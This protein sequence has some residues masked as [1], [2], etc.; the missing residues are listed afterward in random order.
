MLL[1]P[2]DWQGYSAATLASVWSN[3]HCLGPLASL[4]SNVQISALTT[5]LSVSHP[6]NCSLFAGIQLLLTVHHTH[7]QV[8]SFVLTLPSPCNKKQVYNSKVN[9]SRPD[10]FLMV[11]WS[12]KPPHRATVTKFTNQITLHKQGLQ[13]VLSHKHSFSPISVSSHHRM[14]FWSPV[15]GRT[16]SEW[17]TQLLVVSEC[18]FRD[19]P[20]TQ[21]HN[22]RPQKPDTCLVWTCIWISVYLNV[23]FDTSKYRLNV[24]FQKTPSS[25]A[26]T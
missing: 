17:M 6:A 22:I 1:P 16:C 15:C 2:L 5:E 9:R 18:W 7:M 11:V 3:Q 13:S 24:V 26:S 8:R 20:L 14:C 25:L 12:I 23:Y 21:C 4:I 19:I 10:C